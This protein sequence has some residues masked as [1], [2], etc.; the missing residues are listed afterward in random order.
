VF[1]LQSCDSCPHQALPGQQA[2]L[3]ALRWNWGEVYDIG[4]DDGQWWCRRRDG[5]GGRETAA[6]PDQIRT[7]IIN[8]YTDLPVRHHP[9]PSNGT[10]ASHTLQ[11]PHPGQDTR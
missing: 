9:P 2:A 3:E 10:P 1:D 7:K 11:P 4:V 6:T 8:D 5:L